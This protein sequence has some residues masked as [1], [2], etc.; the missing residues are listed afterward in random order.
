MLSEGE[1]PEDAV[2]CARRKDACAVRARKADEAC[3]EGATNPCERA[4]AVFF[5]VAGTVNRTVFTDVTAR[6]FPPPAAPQT[7]N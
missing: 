2:R 1:G 6:K 3:V 4:N 7:T 5:G